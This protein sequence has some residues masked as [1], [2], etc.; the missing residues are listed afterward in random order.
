MSSLHRAFVA[1]VFVGLLAVPVAA[2]TSRDDRPPPPDG[3]KPE[4]GFDQPITMPTDPKA[5]KILEAAKEFIE[6]QDWDQAT[7][8]LQTRL[9]A[10]ED[11][12][13]LLTRK[14]ADGKEVPYFAT[15]RKEAERLLGAMPAKGREYYELKFGPQAK[16]LLTQANEKKDPCYWIKSPCATSTRRPAGKRISS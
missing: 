11:V 7:K 14:G 10:P 1:L 2:Q 6:K 15:A 12:F 5:K 9:D 13:I 3:D 8:I 4:T 16:A